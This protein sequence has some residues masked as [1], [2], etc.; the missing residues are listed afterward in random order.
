[1]GVPAVCGDAF[2]YLSGKK[3][4]YDV[5]VSLD[6]LEHIEKDKVLVFLKLCYESLKKG[7]VLILRT[8]CADSPF[9]GAAAFNDITHEWCATSGVLTELLKIIKF[10]KINIKDEYPAPYKLVNFIRLIIYKSVV[11]ILNLTLNF[12]GIACPN[13][14]TPNMWAVAM[15][16]CAK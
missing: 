1:M 7:G 11:K 6:F 8:P 10:E 3:E 12:S 5:V 9:F 4:F 16:S 14:W 15:K 13:I 2:E